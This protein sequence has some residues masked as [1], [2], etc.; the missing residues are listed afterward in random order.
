MKFKLLEVPVITYQ[1]Q[2]G[3]LDTVSDF[4]IW[5]IFYFREENNMEKFKKLFIT[6]P[7]CGKIAFKSSS[8]EQEF[9]C[10]HCKNTI[11]VVVEDE[12]VVYDIIAKKSA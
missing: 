10:K 11:E 6:C 2:V 12:R 9:V 3:E 1:S 7:V 8:G 4:L 5:L